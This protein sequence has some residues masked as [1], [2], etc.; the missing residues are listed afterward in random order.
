VAGWPSP[1]KPGAAAASAAA[2]AAA[3]SLRRLEGLGAAPAS[4]RV[5]PARAAK[6]LR[7]RNPAGKK[8]KEG[9]G[10]APA[11]APATSPDGWAAVSPDREQAEALD[12]KTRS[13]TSPVPMVEYLPGSTAA[14]L[15]D[16]G[17]GKAAP[18]STPR[19]ADGK[20]ARKAQPRAKQLLSARLG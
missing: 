1:A 18:V 17:W 11:G 7:I 15:A 9:A 16:D 8:E 19:R 14:L 5:T 10:G 12:F 20:G 6:G 13:N 2:P 3:D 4:A